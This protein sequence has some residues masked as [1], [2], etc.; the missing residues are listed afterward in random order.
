MILPKHNLL[1]A[2]YVSDI[3][4]TRIISVAKEKNRAYILVVY[5]KYASQMTSVSLEQ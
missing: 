4:G 2:Y 1:S 3:M 5:I